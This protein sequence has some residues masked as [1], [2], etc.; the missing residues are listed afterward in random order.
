MASPIL[1]GCEKGVRSQK[2]RERVDK[3]L[4]T[5]KRPAE[6]AGSRIYD[7]VKELTKKN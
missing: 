6:K 3:A 7:A 5:G 1:A 4:E 2:A